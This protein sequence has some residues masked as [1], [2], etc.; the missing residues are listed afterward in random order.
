MSLAI[1]TC[2]MVRYVTPATENEAISLQVSTGIMSR[3]VVEPEHII[4]AL[5]Q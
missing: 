2:L 4:H 1:Y 5:A 3:H